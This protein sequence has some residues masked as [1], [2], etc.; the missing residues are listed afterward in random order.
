M[1]SVDRTVDGTPVS[2]DEEN[3]G[4]AGMAVVLEVVEGSPSIE[5]AEMDWDREPVRVRRGCDGAEAEID[6]RG[7]ARETEPRA[8]VS[9]RNHQRPPLS[10]QNNK[11]KKT[12]PQTI[13]S[14][15]VRC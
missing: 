9:R 2:E 3:E 11:K 7:A 5:A 6:G 1:S 15:I 13:H 14:P 8:N 12:Q 10:P 4:E